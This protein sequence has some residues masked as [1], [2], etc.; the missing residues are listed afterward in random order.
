MNELTEV[1]AGSP[2]F[3]HYLKEWRGIL[4]NILHYDPEKHLPKNRKSAIE[5]ISSH[6]DFPNPLIVSLLAVPLVSSQA[7]LEQK[8]PAHVLQQPFTITRFRV[9]SLW[10]TTSHLSVPRNDDFPKL[11]EFQLNTLF[12]TINT[13]FVTSK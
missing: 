3:T 11:W 13:A 6:H 7:A 5:W 1:G 2:A 10:W 8:W 12:E 4:L 9:S